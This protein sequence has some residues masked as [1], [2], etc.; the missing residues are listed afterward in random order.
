MTTPGSTSRPDADAV[1]DRASGDG[2]TAAEWVTFAASCLVIL[3]IAALVIGQLIGDHGPAA[4]TASVG[5]VRIVQE[6]QQVPVTVRNDGDETGSNVTIRFE[7]TADGEPDDAEQT[8][9]F[10]AGDEVVHL[11]FVLP[12]GASTQGLTARVTGFTDP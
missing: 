11:V 7:F 10:L 2:R 12:E 4:P 5:E 8:I 3:V 6:Q 9:D 1:S